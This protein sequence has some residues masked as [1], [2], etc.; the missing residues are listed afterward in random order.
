M[1]HI[2]KLGCYTLVKERGEDMKKLILLLGLSFG[3][4]ACSAQKTKSVDTAVETMAMDESAKE[5]VSYDTTTEEGY[6]APITEKK[7]IKNYNIGGQTKDYDLAKKTIEDLVGEF[8]GY[9]ASSNESLHQNRF[10]NIEAKIPQERS[11][12]F[13]GRLDQIEVLNIN[14]KNS[15]TDDVTDTYRDT[16]L[17]IDSLEKRLDKLYQIQKEDM[18]MESRLALEKQ[19]GDTI[20]EIEE[21]KK[22]KMNLD[23]EIDYAS[24][25]IS[26]DEVGVSSN[27]ELE[28]DFSSRVREAFNSSFD[29]F[30]RAIKDLIVFVIFA[31]P[32]IVIIAILALVI[33]LIVKKS[34]KRKNRKTK[35]NEEKNKENKKTEINNS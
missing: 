20:F 12:E 31:L 15:F 3:L 27:N 22:N 25:S 4:I 19:I 10:F 14:S 28:A 1:L 26:I 6:Q 24:I 18:D 2:I 30:I 13:I 34:R 5:E 11:D 23:K 17:R 7:I 32:F 21:Y 35:D 8:K 33:I 29:N 9:I 16:E